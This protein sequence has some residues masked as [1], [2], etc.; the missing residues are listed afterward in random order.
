MFGDPEVSTISLD[1]ENPKVIPGIVVD[2]LTAPF[3]FEE[4]KEVV[5]KM[6]HNKSRALDWFTAEFYHHF[7]EF[8]KFDLKALFDDFH[9]GNLDI[10]KLNYGI[11]TLVPNIK[12]ANQ[13]QS[14][15]LIGLSNVSF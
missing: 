15:R 5:F 6:S 12:D 2:K 3:S 4:I 10:S 7:W 11:I 8:V 9:E 14:Y 1:V 13:V